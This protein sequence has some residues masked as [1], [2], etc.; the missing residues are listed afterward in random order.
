MLY[1]AIIGDIAGSLYEFNNCTEI[2]KG[3]L[4]PAQAFF[5]DDT[6]MTIATA[7]AILK[8]EDSPNFA[9]AYRKWGLKY[10]NRG[11]GTRFLKWLHTPN[12]GPYNS[13]GNGSAMRI[14]PCAYLSNQIRH[15]VVVKS[16]EAT[17]NH[18]DGIFGAVAT[19]SAIYMAYRGDSK[20]SIR[21]VLEPDFEIP[22]CDKIRPAEFD[23]TCMGTIPLALAAFFEGNNFDEC[24]RLAISLGGDSDTIA[25]I[26]G[27]IAEAYFG[28]P[29][30]L[31][32]EARAYLT[33][34]M[35]KIIDKFNRRYGNGRREK[36]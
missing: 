17:H 14:S 36:F 23:E 1:G 34:E 25:A 3:K 24:I 15:D 5:T 35:L 20:D 9:K 11:Y 26:T 7:D 27:S 21:R 2:L 18:P 8:N 16:A 32:Q 31:I 28:I 6:V 13:Y 30:Y 29:E 19:T 12:M 10:P 33:P 4:L 22:T